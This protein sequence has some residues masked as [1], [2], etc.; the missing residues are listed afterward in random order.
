MGRN[1]F[2]DELA[3]SNKSLSMAKGAYMG[4]SYRTTMAARSHGHGTAIAM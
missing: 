1:P 3:K 4:P 2:M